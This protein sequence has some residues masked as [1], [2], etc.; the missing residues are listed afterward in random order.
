M[1]NS[2]ILRKKISW[3]T[4]HYEKSPNKFELFFACNSKKL[5]FYFIFLSAT[6]KSAV[7]HIGGKQDIKGWKSKI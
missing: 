5:L 4:L 7:S 3:N 1:N 2:F 6:S